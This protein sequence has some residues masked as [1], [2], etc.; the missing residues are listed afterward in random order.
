MMSTRL[1]KAQADEALQR[2]FRITIARTVGQI[3]VGVL[4]MVIAPSDVWLYVHSI[5]LLFVLTGWLHYALARRK[6]GGAWLEYL[7]ATLDFAVLTF[8]VIYPPPPSQ[9]DV[10]PAFFLRFDNFDFLYLILAALAISLRPLLLIWGGINGVVFWSIGLWW[11][12]AAKGANTD[13]FTDQQVGEDELSLLSDE[14]FID[15]GIQLQGMVVFLLVSIMLAIAVEASQRLFVRQVSQ[16]RRAANLS[17]YL[18]AESVEALAARDEPFSFEAQTEAAILFTDVVGFSGMA[19]R[20]TP[21]EVIELL[22]GVHAIVAEQVFAHG[23]TLDKFIG[24]GV[25]AT[26]GAVTKGEADAANAI[27]CAGAILG[28]VAGYNRARTGDALR[29]SI[30]VHYGP[31]VVGDVGSARRMELAV[32][33]DAVNVAA[34]LETATRALGVGAAISEEAMIAAGRPHAPT[35]VGPQR[36]KGRAEPVIVWALP[37][38]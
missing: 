31:V 23:G 2:L 32:I 1:D 33:G 13:L 18:P 26:F 29:I 16:E 36:V 20:A 6:W 21:H 30:G 38:A 10:H 12:I 11:L 34:R 25:M 37:E 17:R 35:L 4:I 14:K 7:A 3:A 9:L 15:L 22:R 8:V 24:D 5:L 28:A 27:D 19:E